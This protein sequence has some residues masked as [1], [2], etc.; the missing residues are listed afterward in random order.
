MT[1]SDNI[2]VNKSCN[3]KFNIKGSNTIVV[4]V[5]E[6]N[7]SLELH[8][9]NETITTLNFAESERQKSETD[10]AI[11]HEKE[12]ADVEHIEIVYDM[13]SS[14]GN[15]N[16]GKTSGIVSGGEPINIDLSKYKKLIVTHCFFN[17][18]FI[19]YTID[20]DS[21]LLIN[22]SNIN[23]SQ[24]MGGATSFNQNNSQG[25][26]SD[27]YFSNSSVNAEKTAFTHTL[28]GWFS[29]GTIS[30]RNNNDNSVIVKIEGAY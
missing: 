20:L 12:I 18:G 3:I 23:I 1:L 7:N 26:D 27:Q 4:D 16:L 13:S 30:A 5:D 19:K 15:I 8:L 11:V 29:S 25:S 24:Y 21:S 10:G 14:D 28:S 2:I 9:D 6:F 17:S 22:N